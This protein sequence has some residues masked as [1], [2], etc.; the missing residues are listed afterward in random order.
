M[1]SPQWDE[2]GGDNGSNNY[3]DNY[4]GVDELAKLSY[5]ETM[6]MANKVTMN[7][8]AISMVTITA[9]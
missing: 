7:G 1:K 9:R 8:T 3:C 4:A 6:K 5:K 2:C